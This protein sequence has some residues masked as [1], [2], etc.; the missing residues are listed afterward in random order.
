M[1][2]KIADLLHHFPPRTPLAECEIGKGGDEFGKL[3]AAHLPR[4]T[5]ERVFLPWLADFGER[6]AR[7]AKEDE[8]FDIVA[9]LPLPYEEAGT[10]FERGWDAALTCAHDCVWA[11]SEAGARSR[12]NVADIEAWARLFG[13]D[14]ADAAALAQ[15]ISPTRRA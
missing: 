5:I 7:A 11:R 9:N 3:A 1:V 12:T 13:A 8:R 15:L 6:V 10:P 4:A 2:S 14:A